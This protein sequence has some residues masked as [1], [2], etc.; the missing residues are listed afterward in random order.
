MGISRYVCLFVLYCVAGWIYES[1]YC[2]V[3][4]GKWENRGFLYG[5]ACPIY[6]TGAVAISLLTRFAS[7]HQIAVEVWKVFL[8]SM[9]G[10]AV[11]EYVTSVVLEKLFHAVWW[12][13]S[14]LPLNIHGRI[15]LFSSIGFGLA[16]IL[17]VYGIAPYTERMIRAIPPVAAEVLALLLVFVIAVDLTLTVTA[18][19]HF[20]RVVRRAS[21]SFN[22][23]MDQL[24][25]GAVTR[26]NRI[27]QEIAEKKTYAEAQARALS[28]FVRTTVKR[29]RFFRDDNKENESVRNQIL[30]V[31]G[32]ATG[33]KN[34]RDDT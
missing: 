2:T 13:Y 8:V 11:L 29:A 28:D 23:N 32:R 7:E 30:S 33:R 19:L 3:K 4:D 27:R 17:V 34:R 6:G 15:S 18:L 14:N 31:I 20:D 22:Q 12:D 21:D 26:T 25:D 1:F 10:S 16:G 5:P 24:V 9:I